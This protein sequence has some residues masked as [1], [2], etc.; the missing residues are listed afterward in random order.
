M[1]CVCTHVKLAACAFVGFTLITLGHLIRFWERYTH[2]S[3]SGHKGE[4]SSIGNNVPRKCESNVL[5]CPG[6][7][8]G[9]KHT[10]LQHLIHLG[11]LFLVL[12]VNI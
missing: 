10:I 9:E 8:G 12:V 11:L 2:V 4:E 5:V 3:A 1:Y 7:M 6:K